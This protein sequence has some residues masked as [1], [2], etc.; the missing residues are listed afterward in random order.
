MRN[1]CRTKYKICQFQLWLYWL[2]PWANHVTFLWLGGLF[3][4]LGI[5]MPIPP[6]VSHYDY[7]VRLWVWRCL[8][9]Q[10][11]PVTCNPNYIKCGTSLVVQWLR[12]CLPMQM[13]WVRALVREDPTCCGATKPV[14]HNY[15]VH[16]PQLLK[17]VHPGPACCNY[18]ANMLQLPK[19]A[20]L[21]PVLRN[22][23]S[24]RNEKPVC[25][26]EE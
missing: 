3:W 26:K 11:N 6:S 10:K 9:Q 25:R 20:H 7:Q 5:I 8:V 12:I 17:P 16:T 2:W 1:D 21:E 22:K 24:H 4:L 15:W 19:P 13:T 23:R 14:S 18:W